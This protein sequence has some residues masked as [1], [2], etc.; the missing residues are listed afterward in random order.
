M[1]LVFT[2]GL[3]LANNKESSTINNNLET[4]NE[5]IFEEMP[6]SPAIIERLKQ[7]EK[8]NK[9]QQQL[10]PE[11]RNSEKEAELARNIIEENKVC[12]F[13]FL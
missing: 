5:Q 4:L 10:L 2:F 13:V 12:F 7:F 8:S 11:R 3:F 9:Q 6:Q 1:K